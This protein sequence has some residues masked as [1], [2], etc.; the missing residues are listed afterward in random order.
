MSTSPAN[1]VLIGEPS[2]SA[3]AVASL[4]AVHQLLDEPL[5]LPDAV[6]LPL[7]G[8]SKEF[9]LRAERFSRRFVAR[10][11]S[12]RTAGMRQLDGRDHVPDDEDRAEDNVHRGRLRRRKLL[13]FRLHCPG[14]AADPIERVSNEL[15]AQKL[16]AGCERRKGR[17]R[18]AGGVRVM[19]AIK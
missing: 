16:A 3:L 19:R 7:P 18:M 13:L 5:V 10:R 12:C 17:L 14:D 1:L 9:P 8:A 4:R 11:V 2:S 15:L 6:A